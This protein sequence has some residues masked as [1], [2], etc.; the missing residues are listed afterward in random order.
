MSCFQIGDRVRSMDFINRSDCYVEV[1]ISVIDPVARRYVGM[2]V[3]EVSVG[4][5]C[6]KDEHTRVGFRTTFPMEGALHRDW[7]TR[8]TKVLP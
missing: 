8:L 6:S 7:P 4:R 1:I 5:D 2:T 3:A